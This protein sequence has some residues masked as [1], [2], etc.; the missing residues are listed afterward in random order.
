MQVRT[1]CNNAAFLA[2]VRKLPGVERAGV[3]LA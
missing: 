1:T 2:E 3:L